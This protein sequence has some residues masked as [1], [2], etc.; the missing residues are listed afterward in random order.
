MLALFLLVF[1]IGELSEKD[2][3]MISLKTAR[4]HAVCVLLSRFV[5]LW[6]DSVCFDSESTV[7]LGSIS[8]FETQC[9]VMLKPKEDS[10]L[11]CHS[12]YS[13]LHSKE[14]P[15]NRVDSSSLARYLSLTKTESILR[16]NRKTLVRHHSLTTERTASPSFYFVM[17]VGSS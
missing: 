12:M 7:V 14:A 10:I 4:I 6:C 16:E 9:A 2:K 1:L 8:M 11:K 17:K 5:V 3:W 15:K 13:T